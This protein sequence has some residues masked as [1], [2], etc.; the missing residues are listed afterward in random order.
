MARSPRDGGWRGA[1]P[2]PIA[3]HR[4]RRRADRVAATRQI[5]HQG[6]AVHDRTA[7]QRTAAA[8]AAQR[9][10]SCPP[11]LGELPGGLTVKDYFAKQEKIRILL[12]E[13]AK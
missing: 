12:Y 3:L 4:R 10:G 7:L 8:P 1:A 6:G 5:G 13:K 11:A 9:L 2:R